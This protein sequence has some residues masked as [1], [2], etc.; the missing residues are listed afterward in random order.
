V[1]LVSRSK[2]F[3]ALALC[4]IGIAS[5]EPMPAAA[6]EK[7]GTAFSVGD[8][9]HL[10]TA[11]HVVADRSCV[12]VGAPAKNVGNRP[13]SRKIIW[14]AARSVNVNT[15]EDVALLRVK[16]PLPALKLGHWRQAGI[17]A[18]VMVL[19]Y[20]DPKV[21]GT[22]LKA[23]GGIVSGEVDEVGLRHLF[24]V[25]VAVMP[26]HSGS[27]IISRNGMVIGL[28]KGRL[29]AESSF[30]ADN[31]SFAVSG[32]VLADFLSNN[33][34][35]LP[36]SEPVHFRTGSNLYEACAGGVLILF[37]GTRKAFAR[38]FGVPSP[39]DCHDV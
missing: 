38:R 18:E 7:T 12:F 35:D 21:F 5:A 28:V 30:R 36:P 4:V 22:G 23:A 3:S 25:S 39:P 14:Q 6:R 31:V 16:N 34:V 27:P 13:Q 10:V 29:R 19:G 9:R 15:L 26:G 11:A 20:P 1:A 33:G 2:F 24:Q 17:G 32:S 37:A 8:G